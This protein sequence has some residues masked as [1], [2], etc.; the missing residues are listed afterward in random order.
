MK[1]TTQ[2]F[3]P[4]QTQPKPTTKPAGT[5]P[6][7]KL[8]QPTN[9]SKPNSGSKTKISDIKA[10]L[11]KK[12]ELRQQQIEAKNKQTVQNT[13]VNN[14]DIQTNLNISKLQV[15]AKPVRAGD[16]Q[17]R[18]QTKYE[19]QQTEQGKGSKRW[20]DLSDW[21]KTSSLGG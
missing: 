10:F 20:A 7:T 6:S 9:N 8:S 21:Y 12:K 1:V 5:V 18:S 14:R 2:L 11:A 15:S 19:G 3:E 16:I 4:D 17:G 13:W